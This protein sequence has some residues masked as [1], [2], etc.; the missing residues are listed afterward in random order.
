MPL[1]RNINTLK[2]KSRKE[3]RNADQQTSNRK[4]AEG[5]GGGGGRE[6]RK[7]GNQKDERSKGQELYAEVHDLVLLCGLVAVAVYTS[8]EEGQER[9]EVIDMR[10]GKMKRG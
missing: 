8:C 1:Q 10:E 5:R 6:E 7:R 9:V 3:G 2:C 4:E